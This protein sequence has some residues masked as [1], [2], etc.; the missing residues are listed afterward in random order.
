MRMAIAVLTLVVTAAAPAT[1]ADDVGFFDPATGQWH[2]PGREPFYF[3]NPG[4]NPLMGDWDCDG[5]ATPGL[6]RPGDG[7]IYLRDS[8]NQGIADR[9]FFFGNP[10][11]VPIAGDWD[12]DGCD[13]VSLFRPAASRVYIIDR[14]GDDDRG[15]GA[16]DRD[17]AAG[18]PGL[19]PIVVP[20]AG[21][22][23]VAFGDRAAGIVE[24]GG[25]EFYF[26]NPGD[27]VVGGETGGL[28]AFRPDERL[29]FSEDGGSC[30]AGARAW[31]PV[32]APPPA[33]TGTTAVVLSAD[34]RAAVAAGATLAVSWDGGSIS[35]DDCLPEA[36][37]DTAM[38]TALS[39]AYPTGVTWQQFVAGPTVAVRQPWRVSGSVGGSIV[40]A[41]QSTGD[42][43]RYLAELDRAPGLT[44]T[45]PIR[46][47]LTE[48]GTVTGSPDAGFIAAAHRRGVSVWPAI[49]SLDGDRIAGALADPIGLAAEVAAAAEAAGADGVNIDLEGYRVEDAAEVVAF[50]AEVTRLVHG[51]GGVTSLDITPRTDSWDITSI[52]FDARFWSQAPLR[53]ELAGAVDYLI[54]MAYDEHNRH[55]PAGPVASPHWVEDVTRYLLRYTDAHRLIL[56]VPFYGRLWGPDLYDP[57]RARGISSLTALE[58]A[59]TRSY[60]PR[61]GLDRVDFADGTYLWSETPQGLGHRVALRD[62]LGLAGLAAWRLGFDGAA[63]WR[64][65]AP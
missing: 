7:Y 30:R 39:I 20:A 12:G 40:L 4:D 38:G 15:L 10:G 52:D 57:P 1:A 43:A 51:W 61:F 58:P 28:R 29:V 53:Y 27:R 48:D 11:D 49:A 65:L 3:G 42:S 35:L 19:V 33:M 13:T 59:G 47:F 56:G 64:A 31:L 63:V 9:R 8:A 18:A 24:V 25:D 34:E 44:V 41:W 37:I 16:A 36:R 21:G 55:R 32:T 14:L 62:D 23:L 46:W 5:I 50:A 26:G 45:S 54:L 60:D 17:Y 22:D 6:H 2:L